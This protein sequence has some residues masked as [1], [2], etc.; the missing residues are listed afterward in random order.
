MF[1]FYSFLLVASTTGEAGMVTGLIKSGNDLTQIGIAGILGSVAIF[2]I[3][4]LTKIYR[5]N[6]VIHQEHVETLKTLVK[7]NTAAVARNS[8]VLENLQNSCNKKQ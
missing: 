6:Q 2:S 7:E 1:N 8:E 4:M 3:Y 5:E